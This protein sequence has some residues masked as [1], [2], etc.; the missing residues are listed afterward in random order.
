MHIDQPEKV[1]KQRCQEATVILGH[2]YNGVA[3]LACLNIPN[4]GLFNTREVL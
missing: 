4:D 3:D 2:E 1:W